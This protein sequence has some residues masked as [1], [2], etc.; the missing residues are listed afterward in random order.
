MLWGAANVGRSILYTMLLVTEATTAARR[1]CSQGRMNKLL[2]SVVDAKRLL[3]NESSRDAGLYRS[4]MY[5]V[6]QEYSNMACRKMEL[7]NIEVILMQMVQRPVRLE[8]YSLR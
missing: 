4:Q 8:S 2:H 3:V 6:W 7:R 5:E 1:R